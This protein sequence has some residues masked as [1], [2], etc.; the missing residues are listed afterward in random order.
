ML[1]II[2]NKLLIVINISQFWDHVLVCEHF[3]IPCPYE[4]DRDVFLP[5]KVLHTHLQDICPMKNIPCEQKYS[6]YKLS[7]KK[8]VTGKWFPWH[9]L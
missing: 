2:I 3:P 4:C 9:K 5:K 1:L 8:D 7:L 6:N